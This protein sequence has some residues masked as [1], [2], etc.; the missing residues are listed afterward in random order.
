[1]TPEFKKL[2]GARFASHGGEEFEVENVLPDHPILQGTRGFRAWD[3]TYV[4]DEHVTDRV[5]LQRRQDEPWTWTR[6]Q[7]KGRVFY[8]AAGHDHRVWDRAEFQELLR[9][10]V[11]WAVGPDKRALLERLQLPKLE[12]ETV[13]LPGYRERKE[14]T[15]AQ[16]PLSPSESQ[17]LAQV[18]TGMTLQLF[19]AEPDIVNPIFVAWDH[20]GRAFVIETVDYPNNLQANNLGHDRITICED[21]DGDGKADKFVRFAEKLSIPTSLTFADGGVIATNGSEMLFLRD[22]DGDDVADERRVLFSG[23]HMGDTHA[24]VSNLR[25]GIDGWVYATIGYSGFGG[26]VGGERHD[27]GQGVFRFRPDGS[28]LEFLQHTTNNTWGL[29]FT[30]DFDVIGSTANGNPSWYFTFADAV[31]DAWGM[32]KDAAPRA[33]DNP[34]FFP[35]SQDIRQVDS[36]DRYTSAA[37]HAVYTAK[38]FP[39]EYHDRI[40]FVCEPTG[41]L[42][43]QFALLREGASF[44]VEQLANN[45]YCS[46]DAWSAPVCAEVGPDGAVWI[47]DWYNLIVQHNP[48][49]SRGSAGVDAKTGKGNAYETPLRDKQHGR[50]WRVIPAGGTTRSVALEPASDASLLAGLGADDQTIRL[51]AQRLLT[52]RSAASPAVGETLATKL[53]GLLDAAG[54]ASPHALELLA[55]TGKLTA[56]ALERGLVA[57][58]AP[59]RRRAIEH[60]DPAMLR[61]AFLRNGELQPRGRELAFVLLGLSRSAADP[62]LGAALYRFAKQEERALFADGALREAW[63]VA[64]RSQAA[65]VLAAAR[66]DGALSGGD[67]PIVNVLPNAAMA[68]TDGNVTGWTDLRIYGGPGRE[69]VKFGPATDGRGDGA[70]LYVRSEKPLDCGVAAVVAVQKHTRYRL[71]GWIKTKGAKPANGSPGMMMNIHGGPRT[72]GLLGDNDWTEVSM[73]FDSGDRT[74]VTVHCLFGGYGGASGEAWWDDVGL[75]ALGG[76]GGTLTG[77]LEALAAFRPEAAAVTAAPTRKF[78][79]DAAVHERGAAVYAR[80]CIACHG[81][82]GKGVAGTFPPLDGSDWLTGDAELPT[83][84]VLHGLYGPIKV[85]KDEYMNAMAPLGPMLSDGDIA[86]VLTYVRQRWSNDAAAVDAASVARVRAATK[87]R[88]MMWT[89]KELGR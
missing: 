79:I 77:A 81:I 64:A 46:A 69:T 35:M 42:V 80:T 55:A 26:T 86:D 67:K 15:V 38:A 30:E 17:K 54:T 11:Y 68:A 62:E 34:L 28:K 2:V 10:A 52:E 6:T 20:R 5:V 73:E 32:P 27:F 58:H 57:S 71:N 40:A 63:L 24:G 61:R 48:T 21:R 72:K 88:T 85:G 44:R 89:A 19:A 14:I 82:D 9:N 84:I 70:S 12:T 45:L 59:L 1:A 74:E 60:A 39:A 31:R 65:A 25:Y 16:K 37:G 47:C 41:K 49:P 33:D 50:I 56:T 75:V 8:T 76:D 53:Q 22:T 66:A 43:G 29:G 87:D 7:G 18:P 51:H 3:E 4:H 83:K 78:A 36:F 13:S 23:F